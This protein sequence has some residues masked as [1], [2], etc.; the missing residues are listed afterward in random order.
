MREKIIERDK[1]LAP[2]PKALN[3]LSPALT[4]P[5]NLRQRSGSA[6]PS[7]RSLTSEL[8]HP[9]VVVTDLPGN[10]GRNNQFAI[11]KDHVVVPISDEDFLSLSKP[12]S[13]A[14]ICKVVGKSFSREFLKIQ[15]IKLWSL[16]ESIDLIAVG[17]GF[18]VVICPS[19][20]NRAAI[21]ADGPW[22]IQGAH[23]WVKC[24]EPGFRPSQAKCSKGVVWVNLPEL[25]LELYKQ[26]I[27]VKLGRTM[28]EVVKIDARTLEGGN[29]RF[30]RL[31][32]L[33][34]GN[35]TPPSGAWLGKSFQPLEF[36]E[37]QWFCE[38]C[39]K[40]GHSGY[41]CRKKGDGKLPES[42]TSGERNENPKATWLQVGQQ[43][44]VNLNG[45][46]AKR[47]KSK[48]R[49]KSAATRWTPKKLTEK[50][51]GERLENKK[52]GEIQRNLSHPR[53][54]VPGE[55]NNDGNPFK[56]LQNLSEDF[57]ENPQASP[58][59]KRGA[60]ATVPLLSEKN[61]VTSPCVRESF[62]TKG[63]QIGVQGCPV[64]VREA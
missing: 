42:A 58:P 13:L 32:L 3:P 62:P 5:S 34:E 60:Q 37:G 45:I 51:I 11:Q 47:G 16:P 9:Q 12:W 50:E 18:Y 26:E 44:K 8:S 14:I 64:R 55:R 21:L 43:K 48:S 63:V 4:A 25:P 38:F 7:G 59:L 40:C 54:P 33:M 61:A 10:H 1:P 2:Q 41:S 35:K 56:L 22:F 24:W 29:K 27:L 28:G 15:L 31:C 52:G 23:I 46:V 39:N 57:L 36:M 49:E 20:Q 53:K 17:R 19:L 6:P 30:A